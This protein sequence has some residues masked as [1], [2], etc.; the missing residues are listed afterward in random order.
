ML[1]EVE[2]LGLERNECRSTAQL[3]PIRIESIVPEIENQD[4]GKEK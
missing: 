1:Q 4:G 3:A 2:Y